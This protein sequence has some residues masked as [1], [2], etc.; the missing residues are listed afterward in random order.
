MPEKI[1]QKYLQFQKAEASIKTRREAAEREAA[2]KRQASASRYNSEIREYEQKISDLKDRYLKSLDRFRMRREEG[3]EM[4]HDPAD[5]WRQY[6]SISGRDYDPIAEK[7]YR[8]IMGSIRYYEHRIRDLK[9][10]ANQPIQTVQIDDKKVLDSLEWK[11]L[12]EAIVSEGRMGVKDIDSFKPVPQNTA[13]SMIPLVL[14]EKIDLSQETFMRMKMRIGSWMDSVG[15]V[16]KIPVV[17]PTDLPINAE[18]KVEKNSSAESLMRQLVGQFLRILIAAYKPVEN[19]VVFL[20]GYSHNP[21]N[22]EVLD[23]LA[24]QG[25]FAWMPGTSQEEEEALEELGRLNPLRNAQ[26]EI[27]YLFVFGNETCFSP[28]TAQL[29]RD[30]CYNGRSRKISVI[31]LDWKQDANFQQRKWPLPADSHSLLCGSTGI[32]VNIAGIGG[33]HRALFCGTLKMTERTL[34][35]FKEAYTQKQASNRFFEVCPLEFKIPP[36]RFGKDR[37]S[38]DLPFAQTDTG[39]LF[40]ARFGGENS[41]GFL[42]GS[43]GSGKTSLLH[44]LIADL[45]T[46]YHPDDM[47]LWLVDYKTTEFEYYRDHMPPHVKYILMDETNTYTYGLI[48]MMAD[49]VR[50]RKRRFDELQLKSD[51]DEVTEEMYFPNLFILIDEFAVLARAIE[52]NLHYQEELA[53]VFS[54]GRYVGVRCLFASQSFRESKSGLGAARNQMSMSMVMRA[55]ELEKELDAIDE[56]WDSNVRKRAVK[57]PRFSMMYSNWAASGKESH[58]LRNLWFEKPD[59]MNHICAYIDWLNRSMKPVTLEE[60]RAGHSERYVD[61]KAVVVKGGTDVS[62]EERRS[63]INQAVRVFQRDWTYHRG[64]LVL[65]PGSPASMERIQGVVMRAKPQENMMLFAHTESQITD[66]SRFV[67]AMMLSAKEN[68]MKT[69]VWTAGG[70]LCVQR[71]AAD[72]MIDPRQVYEIERGCRG[73]LLDRCFDFAEAVSDGEFV[74]TL[75]IV[76]NIGGMIENTKK[77]ARWKR[78]QQEPEQKGIPS[79]AGATPNDFLKKL[80]GDIASEIGRGPQPQT[81][82]TGGDGEEFKDALRFLF[83]EGPSQ[84]CHFIVQGEKTTDFDGLGISLKETFSSLASFRLTAD[85]SV[86]R[87]PFAET[88]A[89]FTKLPEGILEI[90]NGRETTL[91]RVYS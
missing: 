87:T 31:C 77:V 66:L 70:D 27:R 60:Y 46:Q 25:G 89:A 65:F 5:L 84:G 28:R 30:I 63:E 33:E 37:L 74:N 86:Y 3:P 29:I 19:R 51:I 56:H 90:T 34:A 16:I 17:V 42:M 11:S 54:Q 26:D 44:M 57:M 47:E 45:I 35:A 1:Y 68:G 24:W 71:M 76:L 64:D 12:A 39:E 14:L 8:D 50:R 41:F 79:F 83:S 78:R 81:A 72:N 52:L 9:A 36:R 48:T 2:S 73:R 67:R 18:I 88:A 69:E 82:E 43:T 49:E 75:V 22:W 59:D 13:E 85:S 10:G 6:R 23:K 40:S 32:R 7:L 53:Y 55:N 21:D 91:Y 62:Y 80:Q 20:D 61:R 38:I 15:R 4:E 58:F